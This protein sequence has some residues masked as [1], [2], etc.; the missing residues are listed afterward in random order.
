MGLSSKIRC[1]ERDLVGTE[2]SGETRDETRERQVE[3]GHK[4]DGDSTSARAGETSRR[5]QNARE[6]EEK[7]N[8]R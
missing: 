7:E 6:I 4:V 3:K 2:Q 8:T 5:R 1:G